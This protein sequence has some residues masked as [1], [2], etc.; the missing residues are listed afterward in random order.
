[1]LLGIPV[2][3]PERHRLLPSRSPL[4]G[5]RR[6]CGRI[7]GGRGVVVIP[8]RAFDES[9]AW[10]YDT[11]CVNRYRRRRATAADQLAQLDDEGKQCGE[12]GGDEPF[13]RGEC[14]GEES[15][16]QRRQLSPEKNERNGDETDAYRLEDR[17]PQPAGWVAP[18]HQRVKNGTEAHH[19]KSHC[20]RDAGMMNARLVRASNQRNER[21]QEKYER[22]DNR[23][24]IGYEPSWRLGNT[25]NV[26]AMATGR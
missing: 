7:A 12:P 1:M 13:S 2:R 8:S 20:H 3:T 26:N 16:L 9:A 25:S 19:G 5:G 23:V 4:A 6:D 11:F 22:V 15:F 24:R 18:V 10:G 17:W 14:G 21:C